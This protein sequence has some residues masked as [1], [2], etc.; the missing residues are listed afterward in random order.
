MKAAAAAAYQEATNIMAEA[1]PL[2]PVDNGFLKASGHVRMPEIDGARVTVTM[3][4]GGVAEAY[5]LVQHENLDFHH[6]V[7][8]AKFLEQPFAAAKS[9]LAGRMA[10]TMTGIL[11]DSE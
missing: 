4:F 1:K 10:E 8:Q 7:G 9:G 6:N 11:T 5:A 2:C 3:G